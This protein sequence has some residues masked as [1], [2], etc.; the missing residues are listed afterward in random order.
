MEKRPVR[1][2]VTGHDADGK[3]VIL[4][5]SPTPYVNQRGEGNVTQL[6]H[7]DTTTRSLVFQAVGK[8]S[9]RDPYFTHLY[10]IN[11]DGGA[12]PVV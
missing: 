4:I 5:D 12:S 1:R 10:R 8:E 9:G 7:V 11:M 3:A 2:I 6:L